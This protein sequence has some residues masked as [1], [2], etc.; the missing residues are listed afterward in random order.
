MP[1]AAMIRTRRPC[2]VLLPLIC[3]AGPAGAQT[4]P[5]PEEP[6]AADASADATPADVLALLQAV[7][8]E[9]CD[10]GAEGPTGGH[11]AHEISYK[12]PGD[13]PDQA[14]RK[15]VLH[16][17][18]CLGGAYNFTTVFVLRPEPVDGEAPVLTPLT[19]AEPAYTVVYEDDDSEKAVLRIDLAGFAT[20]SAL[21]NVE[22][23][24]DTNELTTFS[25]WRGVGDASSS[26]RY[27]FI[28][29][30][31]TLVHHEVDASYDGEMNPLVIYDVAAEAP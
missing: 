26:A 23:D 15:A 18:L 30:R 19:F 20:V 24:A 10:F 9:E 16:E 1:E 28:D 6:L 2:F 22:F 29:G 8:G 4:A 17:V 7:H 13:P 12:G 3:L 31:F 14:L 11:T 5:A 21:V 25:K 27:R